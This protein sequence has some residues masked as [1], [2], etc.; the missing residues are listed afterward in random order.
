MTNWLDNKQHICQALSIRHDKYGLWLAYCV[1]CSAAEVNAW[2]EKEQV[3]DR[4]SAVTAKAFS[5]DQ[6]QAKSSNR[7]DHEESIYIALSFALYLP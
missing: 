1:K 6:P 7:V 5:T 4:L 3:R 2:M